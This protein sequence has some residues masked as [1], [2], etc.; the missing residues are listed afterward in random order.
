M[1]ARVPKMYPRSFHGSHTTSTVHGQ[2]FNARGEDSR[3]PD[4][5]GVSIGVG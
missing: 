4:P 1:S 3:K 2:H 5:L